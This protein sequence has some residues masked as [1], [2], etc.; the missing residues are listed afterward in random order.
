MS[1][2]S[3]LCEHTK[4][5]VGVEPHTQTGC[6]ECLHAGRLL[7]ARGSASIVKS[8]SG[9]AINSPSRHAT[10]PP[11]PSTQHPIIRSFEPGEDWGKCYVDDVVFSPMPDSG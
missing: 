7:G 6:E 8:R 1:Y 2:M 3:K 11:A 10:Q 9:A 4:A 5:L